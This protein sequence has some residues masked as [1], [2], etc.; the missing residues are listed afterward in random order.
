MRKIVVL[1]CGRVG[2]TIAKDLSRDERLEVTVMDRAQAP[3]ER[4]SGQ[5]QL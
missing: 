2:A 5:G 1:G 3:L 4:L